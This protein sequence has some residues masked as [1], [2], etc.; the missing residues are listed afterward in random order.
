MQ[1]KV[2][3]RGSDL[4]LSQTRWLIERLCAAHKGLAVELVIIETHGDRDQSTTLDNLWPT[5]GFVKEIDRA[6]LAG[7]IDLAVHSLKDVPTEPVPGLVLAATPVRENPGDVLLLREDLTLDDLPANF[8]LGTCSARRALQ[9]RR[10]IP[11]VEIRPIRGNVPTRI[12]KLEE[13]EFDGIILAAAGLARLSIRPRFAVPL[14]LDEFLPA[15]GQGALAAQTREDDDVRRIALAID[16]PPT[17]LAVAAERAF[18]RACGGGCHSAL[19]AL[20]TM[21]GD[22]MHLR[23]ELFVDERPFAAEC[24]GFANDPDA[25]GATLAR[26]IRE[27]Q[28]SCAA[29]G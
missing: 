29:S 21:T 5:G 28:Q 20:G 1:L 12:R 18:L 4:S 14:P 6:L 23:G 17:R 19:G 7:E 22:R 9:F 10:R 3:A 16:H 13:G 8:I 15:P 24:E 25:L 11:Q 2:G 26:S 27:A